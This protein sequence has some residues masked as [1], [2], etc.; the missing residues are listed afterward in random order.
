MGGTSFSGLVVSALRRGLQSRLRRVRR[1]RARRRGGVFRGLRALGGRACLGITR[2]WNAPRCSSTT[3]EARA[4]KGRGSTAATASHDYSPSRRS[5]SR[6]AYLDETLSPVGA[7]TVAAS[8][9]REGRRWARVHDGVV[10]SRVDDERGGWFFPGEL[11]PGRLPRAAPMPSSCFSAYP[12]AAEH[13]PRRVSGGRAQRE[14]R[15]LVRRA[16]HIVF[17]RVRRGGEDDALVVAA[18]FEV[19]AKRP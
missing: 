15:G 17:Q 4:R 14:A 10:V 13:L 12:V 2:T 1:R 5:R 7:E 19:L 9:P 3:G 11:E 16:S 18:G 6:R 8:A